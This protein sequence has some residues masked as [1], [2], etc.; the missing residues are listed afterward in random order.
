[1]PGTLTLLDLR[2]A[3]GLDKCDSE[4]VENAVFCLKKK[5]VTIQFKTINDELIKS[6]TD[7][8]NQRLNKRSGSTKS[9]ILNVLRSVIYFVNIMLRAHL[10]AGLTSG[11]MCWMYCECFGD[12]QVHLKEVL[13][14]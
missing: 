3:D 2:L 1:M 14:Q 8:A 11:Q 13:H 7:K 10:T 9:Y 4:N 12:G 5:V 6:G